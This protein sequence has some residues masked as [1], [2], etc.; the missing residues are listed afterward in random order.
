MKKRDFLIIIYKSIE[1]IRPILQHFKPKSKQN[2]FKAVFLQYNQ[3]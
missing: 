3:V 2:Y 1:V